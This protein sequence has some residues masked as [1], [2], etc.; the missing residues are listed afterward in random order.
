MIYRF[1]AVRH[2]G[3][4]P[5]DFNVSPRMKLLSTV[6]ALVAVAPFKC[7][8]DSMR[9]P[10][11]WAEQSPCGEYVFVMVASLDD[12]GTIDLREGDERQ[13]GELSRY[14]E[15]GLYRT[16]ISDKP[17]WTVDWYSY[18]VEISEDGKYLVRPGGWASAYDDFAVQFYRDGQEIAAHT[19]DDLIRFPRFLPHTVSHFFWR[20]ETAFDPDA[21]T[22][23]VRTKEGVGFLFD[24]RTGRIVDVERPVLWLVVAIAACFIAGGILMLKCSQRRKKG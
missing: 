19:I 4:R 7:N 18:G 10:Y 12:D 23:F 17:L 2:S 3:Q 11:S 22:Y 8:G 24:V 16:G 1:R 13:V 21:Y 9:L 6:L 14:P 5:V 15:S 20:E